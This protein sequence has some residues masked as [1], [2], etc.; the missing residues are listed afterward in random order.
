MTSQRENKL[1]RNRLSVWREA[2]VSMR[3]SKSIQGYLTS[4]FTNYYLP[5]AILYSLLSNFHP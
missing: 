4:V 2:V 5:L 1:Q 3:P